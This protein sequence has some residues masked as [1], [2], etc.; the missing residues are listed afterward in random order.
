MRRHAEGLEPRSGL[1]FIYSDGKRGVSRCRSHGG[2][3]NDPGT[4]NA[5]LRRILGRSPMAPF[6]EREMRGY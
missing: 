2:F 3:D 1:T 4:M 5:I 6:Q